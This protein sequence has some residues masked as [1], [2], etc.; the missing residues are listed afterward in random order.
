MFDKDSF[1][2]I[3]NSCVLCSCVLYRGCAKIKMFNGKLKTEIVN[4]NESV[5]E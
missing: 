4:N 2:M 5:F 3:P 1:D